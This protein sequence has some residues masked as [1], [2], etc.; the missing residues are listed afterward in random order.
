MGLL[1]AFATALAAALVLTPLAKRVSFALGVLDHPGPLKVQRQPVAY[2]GGIAV[3]GALAV[4]IAPSHAA[5][6]IPLALATALGVA[7]D[8]RAISPQ[9][10]LVAQFSI[11]CVAG[12]VDP[13]PGRL[14]FLV[15][16]LGVV[17]LVNAVNLI[18]GMD[19]LAASVVA[20][21]AIGFALLGAHVALPALALCGALLGFLVYNRPPA[22]IYLGDGGSYLLGTAL[23]LLAAR[24]LEGQGGAAWIALPLLVGL[25][26]ADTAITIVRRA[27]NGK[28]LLAGD[29]SHVYDQLAD[30]KWSCVRVLIVCCAIQAAAV[31]AGVA[32][33]RLDIA[34]AAT[35]A[36]ACVAVAVA[37][38]W[39]FGLVTERAV[40]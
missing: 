1:L 26:L 6:L 32:S 27:R 16:A 37:A 33:W 13:A 24:A 21:S 5:W 19:G 36:V 4:S 3:L 29:R 9:I 40:A 14:G 39:K 15:T 11:G 22:R 12:I 31:G 30:R 2:L 20:I 17:L 28:P 25:P 23:A 35:L 7:D 38:V 10:R 18:D 8:V 34:A